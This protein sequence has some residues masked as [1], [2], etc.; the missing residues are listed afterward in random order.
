MSVDDQPCVEPSNPGLVS[1]FALLGRRQLEHV[2]PFGTQPR[3]QLVGL[4]ATHIPLPLH[5]DAPLALPTPFASFVQEA[6]AQ[7]VEEPG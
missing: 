3:G 7:V 4:G 5:V 6:A 1:L 2:V